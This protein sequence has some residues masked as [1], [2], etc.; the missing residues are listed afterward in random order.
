MYSIRI[1][2]KGDQG[3]RVAIWLYDEEGTPLRQL[4]DPIG[5]LPGPID[6]GRT[7]NTCRLLG[8][9]GLQIDLVFEKEAGR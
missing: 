4:E 2:E 7:I 8:D 3:R 5:K 9:E 6:W 1:F